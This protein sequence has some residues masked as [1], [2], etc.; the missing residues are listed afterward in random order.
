MEFFKYPERSLNK[1]IKPSQGS[2]VLND[3]VRRVLTFLKETTNADEVGSQ[4]AQA[5][6]SVRDGKGFP[7]VTSLGRAATTRYPVRVPGTGFTV[8]SGLPGTGTKYRYSC[9]TSPSRGTSAG[10]ARKVPVPGTRYPG[11]G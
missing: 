4:E 7:E 2:Y 6:K 5:A 1:T 9:G 3:Y 11:T 8:K 10:G